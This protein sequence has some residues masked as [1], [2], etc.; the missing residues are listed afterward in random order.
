MSVAYGFVLILIV[1]FGCFG[2]LVYQNL[3]L[4]S[5]VNTIQQEQYDTT[6]PN[7]IVL[8]YSWT[9]EPNGTSQVL[10]TL[11]C[12]ILNA[13][14]VGATSFGLSI[15]AQ[16][17]FG[18]P[19]S[20]WE[21]PTGIGPWQTENFYDLTETYNTARNGILIS[22]WVEPIDISTVPPRTFPP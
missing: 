20:S 5:R 22:V 21:V 15:Y 1:L 17:Q 8:S 7:I 9:D 2:F 10:I 3:Q 19:T 11:N 14:P 13:S 6:K 12:T 18:T 4:Q 16:G